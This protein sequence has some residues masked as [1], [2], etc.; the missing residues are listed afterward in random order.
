MKSMEEQ[1]PA[2]LFLRIHKSYIVATS[3]IQ[4]MEGREVLVGKQRLPVSRQL[5]KEVLE[6][7]TR[8]GR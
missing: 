1:L 2:D 7:I 3:R 6:K 8:S 4:S 5:K